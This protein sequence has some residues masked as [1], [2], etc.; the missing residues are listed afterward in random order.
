MPQICDLFRSLSAA[1]LR[2]GSAHQNIYTPTAFTLDDS[3][4]S[5]SPSAKMGAEDKVPL[6]LMKLWK[7]VEDP[8]LRNVV[9]W[10]DVRIMFCEL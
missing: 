9:G 8:T 2:G 6:F 5:P 4:G 3:A 7:I 1:N 10:D